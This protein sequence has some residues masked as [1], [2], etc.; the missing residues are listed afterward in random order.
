MK[1]PWY[2]R[3]KRAV[4][5]EFRRIKDEHRR[6]GKRRKKPPLSI[7]WRHWLKKAK[8]WRFRIERRRPSKPQM[9]PFS[10]RIGYYFHKQ[11]ELYAVVF[12]SKFLIIT[13]NS[14]IQGDD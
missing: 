6:T 5:L 2:K 10:K 8:E 11:R 9:P 1:P 7:R 3:V 13:L 4:K 12:T 14:R